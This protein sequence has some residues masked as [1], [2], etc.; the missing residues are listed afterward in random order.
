MAAGSPMRLTAAQLS[1][2]SSEPSPL[3]LIMIMKDD[4]DAQSRLLLLLLLLINSWTLSHAFVAHGL[5]KKKRCMKN[6]LARLQEQEG[7]SG[8]R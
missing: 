7:G 6:H 8:M 4:H 3:Q 5:K 2:D 1:Q